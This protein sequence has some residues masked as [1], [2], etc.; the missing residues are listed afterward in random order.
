MEQIGIKDQIPEHSKLSAN[1]DIVDFVRMKWAAQRTSPNDK[2]SAAIK[3]K[4]FSY[5]SPLNLSDELFRSP[6]FMAISGLLVVCYT[7]AQFSPLDVYIVTSKI[8]L[9]GQLH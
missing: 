4:P 9:F 1:V 7:I 8:Q 3:I 5:L 2:D 6:N